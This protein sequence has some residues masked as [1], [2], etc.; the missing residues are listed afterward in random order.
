[1]TDAK[2]K[3]LKSEINKRRDEVKELRFLLCGENDECYLY[4][5]KTKQAKHL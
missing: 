4:R 5:N 3:T 1:M 2:A